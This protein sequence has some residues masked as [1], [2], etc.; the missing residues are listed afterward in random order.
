L[1]FKP[2]FSFIYFDNNFFLLAFFFLTSSIS[3][4]S[5]I[6][7][8]KSKDFSEDQIAEFQEAFQLFDTRGDGMI[9]VRT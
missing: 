9:P 8:G 4:N 5:L 7:S 3:V 2:K 1:K 6:M